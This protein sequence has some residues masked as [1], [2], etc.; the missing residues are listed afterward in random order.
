M[1][2]REDVKAMLE[3][4]RDQGFVNAD[5]DEELETLTDIVVGIMNRG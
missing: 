2:T 1:K 3:E 5:D 4:L